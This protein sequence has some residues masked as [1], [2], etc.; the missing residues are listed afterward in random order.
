MKKI[1]VSA[2]D[3]FKGEQVGGLSYEEWTKA[4]PAELL[5]HRLAFIADRAQS[6]A[7]LPYQAGSDFPANALRDGLVLAE[8]ARN[9]LRAVSDGDVVSGAWLAIDIGKKIGEL[10]RLLD[11]W[12][13]IQVEVTR[14]ESLRSRAAKKA[15]SKS[16]LTVAIEQMASEIPNCSY[17]DLLAEMDADA[18]GQECLLYDLREKGRVSIRFTAVSSDR[19]LY[20]VIHGPKGKRLTVSSL[21]N[22]L[23][24]AKKEI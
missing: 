20:D 10:N 24:A 23:T 12:D 16:P 22:K 17:K 4:P 7:D 15:G 5:R 9:G 13:T 14:R 1:T 19:I 3:L 2:R 6:L 11:A 21:Q 8:I 18:A